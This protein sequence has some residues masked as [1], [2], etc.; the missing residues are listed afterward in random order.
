MCGGGGG[1]EGDTPWRR[2][3]RPGERAGRKGLGGEGPAQWHAHECAGV[4]SRLTRCRPNRFEHFRPV[5]KNTVSVRKYG[6]FLEKIGTEVRQRGSN[7][8]SCA[9]GLPPPPSALR[10][11]FPLRPCWSR[12]TGRLTA[13]AGAAHAPFTLR[14]AGAAAHGLPTR[15]DGSEGGKDEE[16]RTRWRAHPPPHPA[17]ADPHH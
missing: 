10:D 17:S 14:A 16:S 5:R 7:S 4:K 9:P 2:S 13:R 8:R 12:M 6:H 15:A 1:R 11:S 3:G